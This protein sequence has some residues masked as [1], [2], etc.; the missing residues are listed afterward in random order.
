MHHH[1]LGSKMQH[2]GL[3]CPVCARSLE[4]SLLEIPQDEDGDDATTLLLFDCPGGDY[5][6]TLTQQQVAAMVADEAVKRWR[7]GEW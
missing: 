6:S 3:R 2:D 1:K 5:H 4:V 7:A